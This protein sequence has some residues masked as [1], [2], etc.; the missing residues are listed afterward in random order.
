MRAPLVGAG[1]GHVDDRK[2]RVDLSG[3]SCDLPTVHSAPQIDVDHKCP[4]GAFVSLRR[5]T[6]SS[7]DGAIAGSKP[8]SASASSTTVCT[9]G[10]SSTIRI[11]S[12]SAN[13]QLPPMTRAQMHHAQVGISF[14]E[15]CTKVNVAILRQRQPAYSGGLSSLE[16]RYL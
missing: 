4:V 5:V 13:A 11:T 6:A 16:K 14:R 10:S 7:P 1:T 9:C 3:L 12:N 15:N 8:P 2:C